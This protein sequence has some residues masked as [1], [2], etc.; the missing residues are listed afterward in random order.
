MMLSTTRNLAR[1]ESALL[2][3]SEHHI[4]A[5]TGQT[6]GNWPTTLTASTGHRQIKQ[7]VSER[8]SIEAVQTFQAFNKTSEERATLLRNASFVFLLS[9]VTRLAEIT[10]PSV[11]RGHIFEGVRSDFVRLLG[12]LPANGKALF[13][14]FLFVLKSV[15]A[16]S[17]SSSKGLPL[18]MSG[19]DNVIRC[20][21]KASWKA[22]PLKAMSCESHFPLPSAAFTGVLIQ[23]EW[24]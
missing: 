8:A 13:N 9:A 11:G 12:G 22:S 23:S 24:C 4:Q 19:P 16:R 21:G 6:S 18:L 2:R 14:A 1:P 7:M 5:G 17:S 10:S 20:S 3:G 15:A